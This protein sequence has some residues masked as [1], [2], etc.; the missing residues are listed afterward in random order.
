[1]QVCSAPGDGTERDSADACALAHQGSRSRLLGRSRPLGATLVDRTS[2][3]ACLQLV[4][5]GCAACFEQQ[6]R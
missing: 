5:I 1:M 3:A 4:E 6:P 2:H